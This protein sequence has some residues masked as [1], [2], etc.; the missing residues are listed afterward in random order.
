[1]KSPCN[2]DA[3]CNWYTFKLSTKKWRGL[4]QRANFNAFLGG[5]GR[6]KNRRGRREERPS[7]SRRRGSPALALALSIQTPSMGV[8]RRV[9]TRP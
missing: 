7:F 8:G 4:P 2:I 3:I 6:I 5:G 9:N 1:M